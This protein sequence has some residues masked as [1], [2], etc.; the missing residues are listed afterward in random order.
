MVY[1]G[2]NDC[3]AVGPFT[4][5]ERRYYQQHEPAKDS[6]VHGKIDPQGSMAVE[7]FTLEKI[8]LIGVSRYGP[9]C[10]FG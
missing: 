3:L 4:Q 6:L 1:R 7:Y 9:L 5:S 2:S 10:R 8:C